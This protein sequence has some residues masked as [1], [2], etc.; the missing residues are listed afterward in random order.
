MA[1]NKPQQ[2]KDNKDA[3]SGEPVQLDKEPQ[4]EQGQRKPQQQ[5]NEAGGTQ[6]GAERPQHE[7]GQKK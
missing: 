7:G 6:P 1:D 2:Q 5:G 3:E 4:H